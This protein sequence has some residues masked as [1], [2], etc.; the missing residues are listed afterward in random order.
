[1]R[2]RTTVVLLEAL[3]AYVATTLVKVY[4]LA[5]EAPVLVV[6]KAQPVPLVIRQAV[7]EVSGIR[8][9]VIAKLQYLFI[10]DF[11]FIDKVEPVWS[12]RISKVTMTVQL[13]TVA[14]YQRI[15][16]VNCMRS[17]VPHTRHATQLGMRGRRFSGCFK[18]VN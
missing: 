13:G 17:M 6:P 9:I 8:Y 1:M 18:M 2:L 3:P 10:D 14:I 12:I 4:V 15:A 11:S 16:I 7:A 5:Q